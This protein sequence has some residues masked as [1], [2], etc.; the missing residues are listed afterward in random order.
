MSH[1]KIEDLRTIHVCTYM[2]MYSKRSI[3]RFTDFL[4]TSACAT[5]KLGY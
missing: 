1:K 4:Y 2:Y 5:I 3:R